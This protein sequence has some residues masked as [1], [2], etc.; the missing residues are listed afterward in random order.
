MD[1]VVTTALGDVF[2]VDVAVVNPG[3]TT[4]IKGPGHTN[5]IANGTGSALVQGSAAEQ[6]SEGKRS[7]ALK[8]LS[9]EEIP[10]FVPFVFEAG[11]GRLGDAA[12]DFI[13][14]LSV[15]HNTRVGDGAPVVLHKIK[16]G[17]FREAGMVIARGA[18]K[19]LAVTRSGVH[20][21]VARDNASVATGGSGREDNNS[22]GGNEWLGDGDS[23]AGGD[24]DSMCSIFTYG[25]RRVGEDDHN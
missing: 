19:I 8:F 2:M 15:I 10:R 24:L 20:R 14:S 9:P 1:I 23:D 13:K 6:R 18:A 7:K 12:L 17:F 22:L 4:Y 3:G 11:S 16:A 25:S 5:F 21:A